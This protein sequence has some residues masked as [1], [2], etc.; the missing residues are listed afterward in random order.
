[1]LTEATGSFS[2]EPCGE[3]TQGDDLQWVLEEGPR[4]F[5]DEA[6]RGVRSPMVGQGGRRLKALSIF[7][8]RW[9]R[10]DVGSLF[11]SLKKIIVVGIPVVAQ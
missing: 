3:K 7:E 2:T 11:S 8:N 10:M 9:A 1:M 6:A 4:P 5:L